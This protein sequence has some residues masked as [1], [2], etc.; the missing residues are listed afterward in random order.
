MKG[1]KPAV[2][3]VQNGDKVM[4]FCKAGKHRSATMTACVLV[5]LGHTTDEA[6]K[7]VESGRKQ[8]EIKETH[9]ERIRKF[10][11]TWTAVN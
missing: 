9:R 6:I 11:Q 4:V 10:E 1:V 5:G 2:A 7:I 8:A 3:A